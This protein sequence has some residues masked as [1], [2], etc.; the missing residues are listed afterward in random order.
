[1]AQLQALPK[2]APAARI[3]AEPANEK[4]SN[5]QKPGGN[6]GHEFSG[7]LRRRSVEPGGPTRE[8]SDGSILVTGPAAQETNKQLGILKGL[9]TSINI[10][11][12]N[13]RLHEILFRNRFIVE[14]P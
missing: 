1:V 14:S 4:C 10:P 11:N 7:N 8:Y 6:V 12:H 13:L 2:P 3:A 9:A 5:P